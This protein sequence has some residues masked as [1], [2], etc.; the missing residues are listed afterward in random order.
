MLAEISKTELKSILQ[1]LVN[2]NILKQD[3][4]GYI[5]LD[6]IKLVTETK[7]NK[8]LKIQHKYALFIENNTKS[9][10]QSFIEIVNNFLEKYVKL[11]CTERTFTTYRSLFKNH[12]LPY[13]HKI[14]IK[15]ICDEDIKNFYLYCESKNLSPKRLKNTLALLKQLLQYA[16]DKGYIENFC[17]FQVKRLTTKNEFSLNRVIFQ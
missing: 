3:N 9:K 5:F 14:K 6:E 7:P 11:F 1:E 17:N 13:F 8:Q 4:Y 10:E 2:R 12:I 15:N 16:K